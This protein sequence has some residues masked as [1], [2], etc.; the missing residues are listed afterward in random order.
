VLLGS[1]REYL[2]SEAEARRFVRRFGGSE[3]LALESSIVIDR[4]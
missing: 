2:E 3:I 1:W 4:S